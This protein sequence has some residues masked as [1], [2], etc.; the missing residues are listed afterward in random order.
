MV[1]NISSFEMQSIFHRLSVENAIQLS[2]ALTDN[3]SYFNILSAT[4]LAHFLSQTGHES[5]EFS[6]TRENLNYSE[7]GLVKT[8]NKRFSLKEVKG[9]LLAKDYAHNPELI[10]NAVYARKGMGN[11]E[12][13]DGWKFRG[14]GFIQLTGKL[15]YEAFV[16][17]YKATYNKEIDLM[18]NPDLVATDFNLAIISSLW[19]FKTNVITQTNIDT[20]SVERVTQIVNNGQIGVEERKK[21]FDRA[22]QAFSIYDLPNR[23]VTTT[24][25]TV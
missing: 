20:A 22:I 21:Y 10:A 16:S 15:N 14:R 6:K 9:K 12:A 24:A 23:A 4:A 1:V 19:F 7:A 11:T 13:G 18:N 5:M 25:N 2:A 17:F 3:I 8:W